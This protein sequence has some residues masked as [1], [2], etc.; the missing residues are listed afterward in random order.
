[1]MSA[2]TP[3]LGEGEADHPPYGVALHLKTVVAALGLSIRD[4]AFNVR[5]RNLRISATSL[6]ALM[7]RNQ[8]PNHAP[9][10]LLQ[11][12]LRQFL[13]ENG[14][15]PADLT[16]LFH[17]AQCPPS[18]GGGKPI[19]GPGRARRVAPES[20]VDV[21]LAKQTLTP[22]AAKQFKL[23]RNPFDGPVE[24]EEQFFSSDEIAYVREV[25]WQC[26]LNSSF[27]ALIGESGAGKTTVLADLEARMAKDPRGV[28]LLKPGVLG[29]E[30]SSR[31]GQMLKTSDILHAIITT[32]S[33]GDR[34]PATMQA[35]TLRAQQLL[36]A[37]A[38]MG[39]AHLLVVE[40]AHGMPDTTLKHLKRLHEMRFGRR[41]LLGVLLLAQPE[42]KT[43][44]ADGLRSGV[45]REVAQ[46]CEVVE[47]LPLDRDLEPYMAC[48]AT[49][50][51]R[52]LESIIDSGGIDQLRVRLTKKTSGGT[53]S[54]LYPLSVNNAVTRAMNLAGELGAPIV[55][56]DVVKAT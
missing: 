5:R 45:L 2:A 50:C 20:E 56:A 12:R 39:N 9:R 10:P 41:S 34:V 16:Q 32:L 8:W 24:R 26:A 17:A 30:E 6:H 19:A 37:S 40:E 48:R 11:E 36:T 7:H 49:A 13:R 31:A 54:L 1:M 44:L 35:R 4:V 22:A 55:N 33:P 43:R 52:P 15:T 28:I 51:G 38:Q 14:A 53:V 18:A 42:L 29:M 3:P 23:F 47:L 27:Q 46:R 25:M 21:L